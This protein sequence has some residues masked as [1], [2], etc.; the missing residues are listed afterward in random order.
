MMRS[1]IYALIDAH[2]LECRTHHPT[3]KTYSVALKNCTSLLKLA[4]DPPI[5][6]PFRPS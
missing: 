2:I 5:G 1:N 4:K 3:T 6:T